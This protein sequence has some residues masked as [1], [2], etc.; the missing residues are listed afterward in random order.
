MSDPN[1]Q[2]LPSGEPA[3]V[4]VSCTPGRPGRECPIPSSVRRSEQ[5]WFT[6]HFHYRP[7]PRIVNGVFDPGPFEL[8]TVDVSILE[9]QPH[10]LSELILQGDLEEARKALYSGAELNVWDEFRG[11]PLF[12]AIDHGYSDFAEELLAAGADPKLT[13]PDGQTSLMTAALRCNVRIAKIL[14]DHGVPVNAS[15]VTGE[16]ALALASRQCPDGAIVR[17]LLDAGADPNANADKGFTALMGAAS[18]QQTPRPVQPDAP[19]GEVVLATLSKPTFSPLARQA[20]VEGEVIVD[21]TVRQDGRAE[22]T[23]I[24]GQ[25]MLRQS[26]IDSAMQSRFECRG[27][28][29][30]LSYTL[31]YT[32]KRTSVSS[33]CDGIGIPVKVEQEPQSY[34]ERGRP[35]TRVTVSADKICLCDPSFTVPKKVRS[36]KCLFLWKCSARG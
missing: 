25:A 4:W 22:A 21:V 2:N 20:N 33:C 19:K 16:T 18:N 17:F 3:Y 12:E 26:A 14:L 28:S 7:K 36:L 30:P 5:G 11:L 23:V 8:E 13:G 27:C 24:K 34:D 15:L 6:G 1:P 32:F 29:A 35:Q 9:P 31:V 10:S